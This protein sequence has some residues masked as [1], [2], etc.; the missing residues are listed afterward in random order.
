MT[1]FKLLPNIKTISLISFRVL[2]KKENLQQFE[3]RLYFQKRSAIDINIKFYTS[4]SSLKQRRPTSSL[5]PNKFETW[6]I[7]WVTNGIVGPRGEITYFIF[8][9]HL[10]RFLSFWI[11]LFISWYIR[12]KCYFQLRYECEYE[13]L[14]SRCK[15]VLLH[16]ENKSLPSLWSLKSDWKGIHVKR[17]FICEFRLQNWVETAVIVAQ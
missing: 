17:E 2:W 10:Q 6:H 15:I 3:K 1:F 5:V 14:L 4:P 8:Q 11:F 9:A 12:N 16:R 13:W 7:H